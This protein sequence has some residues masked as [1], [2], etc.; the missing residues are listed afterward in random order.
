M[1]KIACS[2]ILL[3]VTTC[4]LITEYINY[5]FVTGIWDFPSIQFFSLPGFR[6]KNLFLFS[7][8]FLII[9]H[10]LIFTLFLKFI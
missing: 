5:L 4:I 10:Y 9:N 2:L 3:Y 6:K 1:N 7:F 8:L